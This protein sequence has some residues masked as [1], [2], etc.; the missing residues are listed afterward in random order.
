VDHLGQILSLQLVE[1]EALIHAVFDD[2]QFWYF[3][4]HFANSIDLFLREN[5]PG[6]VLWTV[7]YNYL[8]L[9]S[10]FLLQRFPVHL[11]ILRLNLIFLEHLFNLGFGFLTRY[12]DTLLFEA[13]LTFCVL[14]LKIVA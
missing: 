3:Q 1:H 13:N 7:D 12:K 9:F 14:A 2:Y 4:S 6:W 8:N 11:P 10:K 5:F